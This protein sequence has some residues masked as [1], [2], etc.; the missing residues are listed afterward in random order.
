MPEPAFMS[1]RTLIVLSLIWLTFIVRGT[2]YS[3]LIPIW[4]GFDEYSHFD[5]LEYLSNGNG[6]PEPEHHI[7]AEISQSLKLA[8][9]P[10]T[11][12]YLSLTT[13]DEF[14]QLPSEE[15]SRRAVAMNEIPQYLQ[16][17]P[18]KEPMLESKQ[19]PLY[20]WTATAALWIFRHSNLIERVFL[21]RLFSVLVASSIVFL[22]FLAARLFFGDEQIALQ[23]AALIT[24]LPQLFISVARVSN[25]PMAIVLFS[26]LTYFLIRAARGSSLAILG[27]E[28]TLGLGLLTKAYFVAAIPAVAVAV[29]FALGRAKRHERVRLFTQIG[30]TGLVSVALVAW[31]YWRSLSSGTGPIWEDAAPVTGAAGTGVLQSLLTMQWYRAIDFTLYSHVWLGGWS[32]LSLRSWIYHSFMYG[33]LAGL[34]GL[35]VFFV[36]NFRNRKAGVE[37]TFLLTLLYAGFWAS[38]MFHAFVSFTKVRHPASGGITF[39]RRLFQRF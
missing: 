22:S 16:Q 11:L 39:M 3:V 17:Q 6:L 20:Y 31:W 19:P 23:V 28:F 32:F 21:A 29:L 7:S 12:S 4:E 34:L 15:R 38:L 13:H 9:A 33:I 37:E 8:P 18:G 25:E 30:V 10:F 14:W 27:A 1:R 26:I 24:A 36:R 2:F 5:F 35:V